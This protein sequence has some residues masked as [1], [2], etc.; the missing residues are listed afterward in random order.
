MRS[1]WL[2]TAMVVSLQ[3]IAAQKIRTTQPTNYLREGP[4][5]YFQI[6]AALPASVEVSKMEK[7]GSWLKVK[8]EQN[9]LGWLSENSFAEKSGTNARD[10]NILKGK[11]TSR[12]SRA[13]LAAAVKGFGKKYVDGSQTGE[14]EISK[15]SEPVVSMDEMESFEHSFTLEPFRGYMTVEK[16]FDIRFHEEGIGLGIAQKIAVQKGIVEDPLALRYINKIGN[17]LAKYTKAYDLGFRFY[18]LKDHHAGAF[19]VPG[20]YI[21]ITQGMVRACTNEA[22]LASVIAHEMVHVAQ[23]HGVKELKKSEAKIK[24]ES[25]FAELEDETGPMGEEEKELEE[26]AD[27]VYQNLIAPRLLSYE[28]DADQLAMTYLKRAGYDPTSLASVLQ[29]IH[30]PSASSQD[31]FDDTY[32]KKDDMNERILNAQKYIREEGY[33]SR[34]DRQ[35]A[36]RFQSNT[37]G[38]R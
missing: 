5:S 25:A 33:R 8:T 30:E 19:A 18:I 22:E 6:I 26:Y 38:V 2:L 28:T 9:D 35:F 7:K 32:M 36:D 24:A 1:L 27:N 20:G 16:P 15:Y 29:R 17:H 12:A 34:T 10:E 11:T 3:I 37:V 31:I 14:A 23:R 4:A 13:E 21:F